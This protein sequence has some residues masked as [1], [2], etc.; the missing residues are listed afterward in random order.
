MSAKG[1][2]LKRVS[3]SWLI[4]SALQFPKISMKATSASGRAE[5]LGELIVK[6]FGESL[7]GRLELLAQS[8][9]SSLKTIDN[10]KYKINR[11][12]LQ[13]DIEFQSSLCHFL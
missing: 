8:Q 13:G 1:S 10:P 9:A 3:P 11:E 6:T 4:K 12:Q 7:D 2:Q 5:D